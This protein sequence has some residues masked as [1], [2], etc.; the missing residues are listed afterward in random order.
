MFKKIVYIIMKSI[1]HIM[2]IEGR[3]AQVEGAG[4]GGIIAVKSALN[5]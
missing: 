5:R 4:A 1:L 3:G 2:T